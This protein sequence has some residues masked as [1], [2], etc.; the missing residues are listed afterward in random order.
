MQHVHQSEVA[1]LRERI[2]REYEAANRVFTDFTLT[3]RH[4]YITKRQENIAACFSE[5]KQYMSSEDAIR[6]IYEV[7]AQIETRNT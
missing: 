7:E 4:E 3:A 5:L 6:M 2:Q 1:R